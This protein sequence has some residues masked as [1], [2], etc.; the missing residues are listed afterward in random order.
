MSSA[1]AEAALRR[2]KQ[3]V[4]AV[5]RRLH[6][7]GAGAHRAARCLLV[8]LLARLLG[9]LLRRLLRLLLR[10]LLLTPIVAPRPRRLADRARLVDKVGRLPVG[11]GEE[12]TRDRRLR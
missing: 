8:R 4:E 9:L 5:G 1:E 7:A 2:L 10:L 3:H 11:G 6:E 12:G